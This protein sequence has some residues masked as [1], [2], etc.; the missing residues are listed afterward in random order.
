MPLRS[1]APEEPMLMAPVPSEPR[2]MYTVPV[3]LKF[4]SSAVSS[5][6]APVPSLIAMPVD[7]AFGKR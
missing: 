2:P 1:I 6:K 7:V 3:Q 4:S 5:E